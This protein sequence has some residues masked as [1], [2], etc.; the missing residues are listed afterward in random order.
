MCSRRT[1]RQT[2][3]H[4]QVRSARTVRTAA[5]DGR[6]TIVGL[7]KTMS[8]FLHLR[9]LFALHHSRLWQYS[10]RRCCL[11]PRHHPRLPGLTSKSPN[12]ARVR[13]PCWLIPHST[14][15]PP[16]WLPSV[17]R[18]LRRT[19]K[20]ASSRPLSAT[21][22]RRW[23]S[24]PN[25]VAFFSSLAARRGRNVASAVVF[26]SRTQGRHAPSYRADSCAKT[27]PT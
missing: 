7:T 27:R 15:P 4:K 3:A 6:R 2:V 5:P 23:G 8:D 11:H 10:C 22:Y 26:A 14:T 24:L 16:H 18:A 21:P 25:S 17:P 1:K 13:R 12:G 20:E 9:R 19:R